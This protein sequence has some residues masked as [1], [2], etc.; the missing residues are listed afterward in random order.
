MD[1]NLVVA[2]KCIRFLHQ[3]YLLL[4]PRNYL[5]FKIFW[6]H[7]TDRFKDLEMPNIVELWFGLRIEQIFDIAQAVSKMPHNSKV[8]KCYSK[9]II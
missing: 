2:E 5:N 1:S 3:K 4:L 8:V 9:I 7:K 6:T